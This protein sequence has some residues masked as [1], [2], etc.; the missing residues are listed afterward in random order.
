MSEVGTARGHVPRCGRLSLLG[1][2]TWMA[3]G[4]RT[5]WTGCGSQL[6][7]LAP[8]R[9]RAARR[10][11]DSYLTARAVKPSVIFGDLTRR[12]S[13]NFWTTPRA[14]S[15]LTLG[16]RAVSPAGTAREKAPDGV[17]KAPDPRFRRWMSRGPCRTAHA[18]ELSQTGAGRL[19]WRAG[20][21]RARATASQPA[22]QP[23]S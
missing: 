22:S 10:D 19:N 5:C 7:S 18:T 3:L 23:E 16:R 12:S 21:F 11:L 17:R 2:S 9:G 4:C 8:L 13:K 20:V 1:T 14:I 15:L 6:G